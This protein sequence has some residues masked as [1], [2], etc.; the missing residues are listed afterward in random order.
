MG[1]DAN[2]AAAIAI[3]QA[4]LQG[5][6]RVLYHADL[7]PHSLKNSTGG[8]T[9]DLFLD[10]PEIVCSSKNGKY[11]ALDLTG[12]GTLS[13]DFTNE[14]RT[15]LF[16]A[17]I[18]VK[19]QLSLK[20]AMFYVGFEGSTA[21]LDTYQITPLSGGAFSTA[22][23]TLLTAFG[24]T[25]I[26]NALRQKL[27]SIQKLTS[28]SAS[29]LGDIV[30]A[31]NT[32]LTAQVL[33]KALAVGLDIDADGVKT[34]GDPTLLTDFTDGN[35]IGIWL[36]PDA[37]PIYMKKTYTDVEKKVAKQG[38]TLDKL[39]F[40]LGEGYYHIDGA[41]HNTFGSATFSMNIIPHLYRFGYEV[42][43][44]ADESGPCILS[45]PDRAELWFEAQD[46]QVDE[47]VAGWVTF[48]EVFGGI[49]TLGLA[50]EI[51]EGY[52][53][54]VINNTLAALA[55]S[56]HNK[57]NNRITD[58]YLDGTTEPLMRLEL[59]N[60]ECHTEG[61]FTGLTLRGQFPKPSLDGDRNCFLES[62]KTD[63]PKYTLTLPFDVLKDDP[64]M[65]VRW[66]I[67]R[68]DT[69]AVVYTEEGKVADEL[70]LSLSSIAKTLLET[71]EF[72]IECRLYRLLGATATDF[73]NDSC[74]LSITDTLDRSHPYAYWHHWVFTPIVQ[75]EKDNS[76]TVEGL[77]LASRRSKIHRTDYPGRCKMVA[78]Y[79]VGSPEPPRSP[80][81]HSVPDSFSPLPE[82]KYLDKLPFP[83]ADLVK[84][85]AKLCDYCFFGG[86]DK[87]KPLV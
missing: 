6:I 32:T 56:A 20:D 24:K 45:I 81:G 57:T 37:L 35:D 55:T 46:M 25:V 65:Q 52:K 73:F 69:N 87:T 59:M 67:R 38:A 80:Y 42:D 21:I 70:S 14:T 79:S 17:T 51:V 76:H 62:V 12:W 31:S 72:L 83:H 36:S 54:M 63:P 68:R 75:V 85:R 2:Y 29:F 47:D 41:A 40:S 13:I 43:L 74:K 5:L 71:E 58:Y 27:A 4:L 82:I 1:K 10:I 48:L 66:T 84:N 53:E 61:A 33:D 78:K 60:H 16:T 34:T 26:Q 50:A 39:T 11:L 86:P 3:R 49:L 30:D 28:F 9:Y 18:R 77:K 19:P 8:I 22:A 23:Q 7:I 15:V 64:L 44:G